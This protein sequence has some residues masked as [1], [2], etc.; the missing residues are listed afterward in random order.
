[1]DGL[2]KKL[3]FQKVDFWFIFTHK[4]AILTFKLIN[5]DAFVNCLWNHFNIKKV[6]IQ[7]DY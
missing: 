6:K 3:D 4:T 1:M 7:L 2:S 5:F